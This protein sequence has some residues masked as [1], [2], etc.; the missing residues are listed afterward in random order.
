MVGV[1]V[2]DYADRP[3]APRGTWGTKVHHNKFYVSGKQYKTFRKPAGR[4]CA[5]FSSTGAGVNY[6]TDNEITVEHQDPETS[7][8][9]VA[10]Y[11]GA[12]PNAGIYEN[13]TITSNV[14]PTYLGV[15][16]GRAGEAIFKNNTFIKGANA[17]ADYQPFAMGYWE[18]TDI[19]FRSNVFRGSD[20]GIKWSEG[21]PEWK[22]NT[23][24]VY[25][26]LTIKAAD[27]AGKPLTGAEVTILDK[28]GAEVF[29]Q[30]TGPEGTVSAELLE[31]S[32]A[33]SRPSGELEITKE[34]RS[35]YTVKLAG[36]ERIVELNKNMDIEIR[37]D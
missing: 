31:Y 14:T 22:G 24:S 27:G 30:T 10:F 5:I 33:A 13:N 16:Y 6:I 26:T 32:A 18:A 11:I 7:A 34:F 8:M 29:K 3:D 17:A 2:S 1:R 15:G 19:D 21:N 12:S 9:A 37:T 28:A 23:Y 35:P 25:W 36:K 20:F 4:A